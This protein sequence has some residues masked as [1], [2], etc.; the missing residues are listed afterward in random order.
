MLEIESIGGDVT[1]SGGDSAYRDDAPEPFESALPHLGLE[2]RRRGDA[3]DAAQDAL[4]SLI[5][6]QARPAPRSRGEW[7]RYFQVAVK[8]ATQML[9][10]GDARRRLAESRARVLP[11][12]VAASDSAA[13]AVEA[14]D[15]IADVMERLSLKMR[16]ILL[17]RDWLGESVV[18]IAYEVSGSRDDKATNAVSAEASRARKRHQALNAK[19]L[20]EDAAALSVIAD[21]SHL[22]M[23]LERMA[24]RDGLIGDEG[25]KKKKSGEAASGIG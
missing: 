22:A 25:G 7:I 3:E 2:A 12:N 18:S 17:R 5:K 24:R 19:Y 8:R 14:A 11:G 6:K 23:R 13:I 9:R 15:R 16:R 21:K 1:E 20:G 10:R 4:A